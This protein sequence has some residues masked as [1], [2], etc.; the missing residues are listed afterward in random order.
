M[1]L[2]TYFGF[3]RR[4]FRK[5]IKSSLFA[6]FLQLGLW[7][8]QTQVEQR[9]KLKFPN[10]RQDGKERNQNLSPPN[11]DQQHQPIKR[12]SLF[13]Q[14]HFNFH[15]THKQLSLNQQWNSLLVLPSFSSDQLMLSHLLILMLLE[16]HRYVN[17]ASWKNS[18]EEEIRVYTGTECYANAAHILYTDCTN[19]QLCELSSQA[20]G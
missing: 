7:A 8:D 10:E 16:L 9:A 18:F 15:F 5:C 3:V 4:T 1:S 14:L 6:Q 19:I 12:S 13:L 20:K 2:L 11:K 17:R